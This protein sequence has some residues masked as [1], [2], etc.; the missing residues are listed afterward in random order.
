MI[1]KNYLPPQ[2]I[3]VEFRLDETTSS[4]VMRGSVWS[5]D[6][7]NVFVMIFTE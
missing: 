7:C 6:L 5:I 1:V 2:I 3:V 4:K